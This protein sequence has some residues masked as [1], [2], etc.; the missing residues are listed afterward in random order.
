V[1]PLL[2]FILA[3]IG[4]LFAGQRLVAASKRLGLI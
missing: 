1:D 4:F 3:L 2:A